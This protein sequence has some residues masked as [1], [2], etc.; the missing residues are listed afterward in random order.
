MSR[1]VKRGFTFNVYKINTMKI[2]KKTNI[3]APGGRGRRGDACVRVLPGP[4]LK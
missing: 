1:V 4:A 3:W 2:N